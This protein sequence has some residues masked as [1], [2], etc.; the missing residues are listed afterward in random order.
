MPNQPFNNP[1]NLAIDSEGYCLHPEI[2]GRRIC[3]S[4]TTQDKPCLRRPAKGKK[5]CMKHGGKTPMGVASP[6]YVHGRY[7]A[8][9]PTHLAATYQQNLGDTAY[10]ELREEMALLRTRNA[11]LL[12]GLDRGESGRLWTQ[13]QLKWREMLTAQQ[14]QD[15]ERMASRLVEIGA[16][17][18]QGARDTEAW[19]EVLEI[20]DRQVRVAEKEQRRLTTLEQM[21]TAERALILIGAITSIITT[22]VKD[23][24]TL[25]AISA[26]IRDLIAERSFRSVGD[27]SR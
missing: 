21:I 8:D 6:H 20:I 23:P 14:A 19:N 12:R 3:G 4:K 7:S 22:H 24:A 2:K 18:E 13:L 15:S 5:R 1:F 10:V 16:L 26:A 25:R 17:I 11:I 27:G 9:L